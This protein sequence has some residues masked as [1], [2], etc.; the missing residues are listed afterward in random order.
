MCQNA[1][2]TQLFFVFGLRDRVSGVKRTATESGEILEFRGCKYL[3]F[4]G[5]LCVGESLVGLVTSAA[6]EQ[7]RI[8]QGIC[9]DSVSFIRRGNSL[10]PLD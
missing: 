10:F 1:Q 9:S 3:L 8:L 6:I 7:F 5:R 2:W 4:V